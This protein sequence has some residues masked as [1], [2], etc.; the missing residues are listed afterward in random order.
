MQRREAGRHE[1]G[2]G[3]QRAAARDRVDEPG[4]KRGASTDEEL[5]GGDGSWGEDDGSTLVGRCRTARWRA[6][7]GTLR[8]RELRGHSP[9]I[10]ECAASGYI[11]RA[12]ERA[13]SGR[14]RISKETLT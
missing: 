3:E 7:C 11:S 5:G 8:E 6:V 2:K 14:Q 9:G 12:D 1:R 13:L 10:P 4:Q